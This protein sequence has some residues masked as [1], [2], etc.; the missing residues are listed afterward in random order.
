[1][2][3]R[4]SYCSVCNIEVTD[5]GKALECD[6][7]CVKMYSQLVTM[8]SDNGQLVIRFYSV[9]SWPCDELTGSRFSWGGGIFLKYRDTLQ[10]SVQKR[11]NQSR[12]HLG[13]GFRWAQG[14][15][16]DRGPDHPWGGV[17]LRGKEWPIVKY[18]DTLL[19]L[20]EKRLN[21]SKCRLG[22]GLGWTTRKH[23]LDRAQFPHDKDQYY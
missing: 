13:F 21:Q 10:S 9:I 12:Y 23:V 4:V 19:W 5:D 6:E 18:S 2:H 1:M 22:Y 15:V 20:V 8:P 17:I 7:C 3:N 11:L 14:I 16:L